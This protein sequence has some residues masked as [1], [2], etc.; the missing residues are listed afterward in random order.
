MTS[1][2]T[3]CFALVAIAAP[4]SAFAAS[5]TVSGYWRNYQN[6]G[7]YCD[8][9]TRNC[10]SARYLESEYNT[11]HP[12]SDTKIYI[13]DQNGAVIGQGVTSST[14]Y[15][16]ITWYRGSTPSYVR[17]YWYFEHK[18]DRFKI[19]AANNGKLAKWSAPIAVS[20]GGSVYTGYHYAGTSSAISG[21]AN[22]YDGADR[23]W[24]DA[25]NYS[26]RMKANFTGLTIRA[27]PTDCPTACA[28][29]G[30]NLI[31]MPSTAPF[32]PQARILHEM[33]HIAA[34]KSAG[35]SMD[36]GS[37]CYPLQ[38]TPSGGDDCS[39]G[40]SNGWSMTSSEWRGVAL[41]EGLATFIGD[42]AIYWGGAQDPRTCNSTGECP[43]SG[44]I[45]DSISCSGDVGRRAMQMDR[46]MWDI[47]DTKVDGSDN[48]DESYY[49]FFDTL[50]AIPD[51][52]S[53]GQLQSY[54]AGNGSVDNWDAFHSWEWRNAMLN[55]WSHEVDTQDE[56]F[57]NCMGY[58]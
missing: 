13:K 25:L 30:E 51:G 24:Y 18:D 7:N 52:T 4:T 49:A 54:K 5:G 10:A 46:Y 29:S 31:K 55:H 38:E 21:L 57:Q 43:V 32:K 50:A 2:R 34:G 27:Y 37:Y 6:Q 40:S 41:K 3:L 53:W 36:P 47:Y 11:Y 28:N 20:N 26:N 9:N 1:L 44:S 23:M 8:P 16:N 35:K 17:V 48:V 22:I 12:I 14:G 42:V 56:Y 33:G 45:E 15:F 39:D 58:F 19:R